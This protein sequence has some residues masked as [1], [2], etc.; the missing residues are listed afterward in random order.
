MGMSN[1]FRFWEENLPI[2]HHS[3]RDP[4]DDEIEFEVRTQVEDQIGAYSPPLW[5]RAR[6]DFRHESPTSQLRAITDGRRELMEMIKDVPES[7]YE[8]SLKDIVAD[9]QNN[10]EEVHDKEVVAEQK[11]VKCTTANKIPQKSSKKIYRT[12]SMENEVFLL[13]MFLPLSLSFNKK[14]SARKHSKFIRADHPRDLRHM[15]I[16][17]GGR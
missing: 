17:T 11:K 14:H 12:E 5:T 6:T 2:D 9:Q 13:K 8:L 7:S 15:E 16:K 4:N 10:M 1:D 3:Y